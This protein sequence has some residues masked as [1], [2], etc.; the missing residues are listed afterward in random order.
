M[1][2]IGPRTDLTGKRYGRLV[3]MGLHSKTAQN[4]YVWSCQ[5]DCGNVVHVAVNNLKSGNSTSCGCKRIE[6]I[7]AT[8]TR[9]AACQGRQSTR[10]GS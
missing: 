1:P 4:C 8:H 9:H 7:I 3:V 5:C 10:F 2:R 6:S